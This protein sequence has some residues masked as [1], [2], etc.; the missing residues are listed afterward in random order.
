MK[1]LE[2]KMS[3]DKSEHKQ[4]NP[5]EL[6][7]SALAANA[8]HMGMLDAFERMIDLVASGSEGYRAAKNAIQEVRSYEQLSQKRYDELPSTTKVSISINDIG[9]IRKHPTAFKSA[10]LQIVNAQGGMKVLADK[11]AN[12]NERAR[13]TKLS[14]LSRFFNSDSPA[15]ISTVHTIAG[16]LGINA[17]EID[18]DVLKKNRK[19]K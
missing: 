2:V 12:K 14:S 11:L 4:L 17:L 16:A 18:R 19:E 10:L 13:A 8:R 9:F 6:M 3:K 5:T 1:E 15:R 7:I